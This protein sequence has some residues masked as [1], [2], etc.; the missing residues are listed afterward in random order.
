[1]FCFYDLKYLPEIKADSKRTDTS[2][3]F[4]VLSLL[5]K[6]CHI[7]KDIEQKVPFGMSA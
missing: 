4:F 1:M 7:V 2:E 3:C 5:S 6:M